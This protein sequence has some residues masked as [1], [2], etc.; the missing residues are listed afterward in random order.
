M[1]Y[2]LVTAWVKL[3]L[4]ALALSVAGLLAAL[5][6][7]DREGLV[8]LALPAVAV[9]ALFSF[10][11][12]KNIGFRYVL[13]ALPLLYTLAGGLVSG[14]SPRLARIDRAGRIAAGLAADASPRAARIDRAGRIAAVALLLSHGLEA[15]AT[16][17]H[18]LSYFNQLA[19]GSRGGLY[20]LADSNLDWGQDLPAL[21]RYVKERGIDEVQLAY[22]GRVDPALYG[23][24]YRL[25]RGPDQRGIAAI[26]ASLL[27]G[28][29]Y[30]LLAE[31]AVEGAPGGY[32]LREDA[33]VKAPAGYY[34]WLLDRPPVAVLGGSIY[35]FELR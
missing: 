4:P 35:V 9:F 32:S 6:R 19:G 1:S 11:S 15:L 21:A 12:H 5:Y 3:T 27:Q 20:W 18:P 8:H 34:R 7:R 17:P 10:V 14:V 28:L 30:V 33:L 22:F 23:I 13:P 24:R 29:P 16:H 25:L 2:F 31:G 26:S